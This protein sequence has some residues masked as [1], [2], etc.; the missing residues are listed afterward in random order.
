M[1]ICPDQESTS[2]ENITDQVDSLPV[3]LWCLFQLPLTSLDPPVTIVHEAI[4]D[5]LMFLF[6]SGYPR[7]IGLGGTMFLELLKDTVGMS[8][9]TWTQVH[10]LGKKVSTCPPSLLE[11][12]LVE[13]RTPTHSVAEDQMRARTEQP[14]PADFLTPPIE[15]DHLGTHGFWTHHLLQDQ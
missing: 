4:Q 13:T 15:V 3:L 11:R 5:I 7:I 14:V 2:E 6:E 12:F 1:A 8:L 10:P 9:G